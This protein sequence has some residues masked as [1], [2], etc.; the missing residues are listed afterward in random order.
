MSRLKHLPALAEE[1]DET[2]KQSF[3]LS[4]KSSSRMV[5]PI[6]NGAESPLRDASRIED[7][8]RE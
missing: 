1:S 2:V 4:V 3:D 7:T 5:G 6:N 8:V